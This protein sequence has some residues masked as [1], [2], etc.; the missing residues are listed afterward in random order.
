MSSAG[1]DQWLDSTLN[2][3]LGGQAVANISLSQ[4]DI[5][6]EAAYALQ[7]QLI[8]KLQAHGGW[9]SLLGYKAALTALP[10][11]Q[12][13]GIDEPIVGALFARQ[14]Y[15]A[16]TPDAA[17]SNSPLSITADRPILLETELGFC[18]SQTITAPVQAANVF[19]VIDSCRGMIELAAPDLQQRPN[20]VD[21]VASNSASYGCIAAANA[22]APEH[23]DLDE[24]TITLVRQS[25]GAE[26]GEAK[27]QVLHSASAGS[28]M[29]SQ[30]QALAWLINT[31]LARGYE[32]RASHILMTGSIGNMHPGNPGSYRVDFGALGELAF[33]IA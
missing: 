23:L 16:A 30:R 12:A 6:L 33:A 4:P 22:I 26:G 9:G 14:A 17:A 13:M 25:D 8:S 1:N 21:L 18:L 5:G 2:C 7:D 20:S 32:L 24:L 31:L 11:Q 3:V 28:V 29:G 27:E 19:D 15:S 10:A